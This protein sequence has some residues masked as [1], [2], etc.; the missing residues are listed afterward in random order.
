MTTGQW[1]PGGMARAMRRLDEDLKLVDLVVELLDARVPASSRNPRLS[2]L[3][4]LKQRLILLHKADRGDPTVT[5]RWISYLKQS[6]LTALPF[7]VRAPGLLGAFRKYLKV[8]QSELPSA[9]LKRPLRLI[10]AGIPNVGKSTL[11]N[12]LVKRA[13]APTGDRPGVTRGRQWIRLLPGVELLD[14]PGVLW[15]DLSG[16][17]AVRLAVV[18]ALPPE[19]LGPQNLAVWLLD[20][21]VRRGKEAL[22][23][24]R[25]PGL[26]PGPAESM[27]ERV[28]ALQGCLLP[29]G[30]IDRERTAALLLRDYQN[31]AL[32]R[33]SLEEPEESG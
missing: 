24:H 33:V 13:A 19:R 22:L 25:Y 4:G 28:G 8:R 2:R 16:E 18:G 26:K 14:T 23:L 30:K 12:Y 1:Y 21:Y 17:A 3:I 31:G 15:P 10:V 7:S 32:G 27:L 6:G 20:F 11:I 9:R 29:E 5:A